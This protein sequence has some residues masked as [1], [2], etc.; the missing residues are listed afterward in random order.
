MKFNSSP[1]AALFAMAALLALFAS[2]P[3]ALGQEEEGVPVVLDEPVVQVNNDVI[4]L[5]S[6]NRQLRDFKE[7]LAKRQGVTERQVEEELDKRQP[8]IIFNLITEQLLLQ[9]GKDTPGLPERVEADVNREMTRVCK[10]QNLNTMER[11]EEAM[12]GEGINPEE[13]RQ[14]LRAQFMKQSVLQQ[15]VDAKIYYGFTEAELRK[16]YDANRAKFQAVTLSEIFLSSA[17][18]KP[19]D[20]RAKAA[21]LI[22]QARGGS[23][24]GALA[25]ANSEREV[26]G[27][28]AAL[29]T[30]G[31]LEGQDGKLRWFLISELNEVNPKIADA[32]RPLKTGEVSEPV[33]VDEGFLL[34]KVHER[35]D[36]YNEAQVRNELL[37]ERGEKAR[38]DYIAALRRDA[39]IKPAKNY[40]AVIQPLL[41]KD[42]PRAAAKQS[43]D[44]KNS[45]DNKKSQ[46]Q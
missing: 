37:R 38:E 44:D 42:A 23:D 25:A 39:Y 43:A 32:I 41:D 4:M 10:G 11:C 20:V 15:E 9:K 1:R 12:R 45:K 31:R 18:R 27:E 2:A 3:R 29:K 33:Q 28:R 19:E 26:G 40:E 35:D 21:Q 17:G 13:I 14:T 16:Y 22:A 24:F 5:S 36:A 34:F 46:K 8:E 7:A 6:L 30:K